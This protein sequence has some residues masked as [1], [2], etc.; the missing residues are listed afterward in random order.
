[1]STEPFLNKPSEFNINKF[2][3][4]DF[5]KPDGKNDAMLKNCGMAFIKYHYPGQQYPRVLKV[6]T[7][8]IK[9][10]S[11]VQ[12]DKDVAG[13]PIEEKQ[14]RGIRIHLDDEQPAC[15]EL[16]NMLETI[17]KAVKGAKSEDRKNVPYALGLIDIEKVKGNKN[18]NP[19]AH[20]YT[21]LV[22][23]PMP[24]NE[25]YI[26]EFEKKNNRKYDVVT[27][28][29]RPKYMK[30]SIPVDFNT[31]DIRTKIFVQDA[32]KP[33]KEVF[34]HNMDDVGKYL[35]RGSVVRFVLKLTKVWLTNLKSGGLKDFGIT[36]TIEQMLITPNANADNTNDL[37]GGSYFSD[38]E[39]DDNRLGENLKNL[40][41]DNKEQE[42]GSESGSDSE[43]DS[44]SDK[45]NN[46]DEEEEA[47][48]PT[49]ENSE[50]DSD[51][52]VEEQE[53]VKGRGKKGSPVKVASKKVT[54]KAKVVAKKPIKK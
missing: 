26:A 17:D 33:R 51:E 54:P 12:D 2:K 21:K 19:C 3:I 11:G 8:P 46:S 31:G 29:K 24:A 52:D 50:H 22:R 43:N 41:D 10:R 1:M 40:T 53:V 13:K 44:E 32:G 35:T 27:D 18:V 25:A 5:L 9:M 45:I 6:K 4:E 28:D 42:E 39:D 30:A 48:T 15:A 7:G 23:K 38:E 37:K 20:K 47:T 16:K 49:L 34:V 36:V 14:R